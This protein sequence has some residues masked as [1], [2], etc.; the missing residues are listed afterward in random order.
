MKTIEIL[1][2]IFVSVKYFL[3]FWIVKHSQISK[4]VKLAQIA[5]TK[6]AKLAK[7]AITKLVK[8]SQILSLAFRKKNF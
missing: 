1:M 8:F 7:I 4:L 5:R 3:V 6:L 2:K